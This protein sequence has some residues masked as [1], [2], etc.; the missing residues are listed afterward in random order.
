MP[1][2]PAVFDTVICPPDMMVRMPLLSRPRSVV[3]G[4]EFEVVIC[5]P[6]L[7][8]M[9]P[10]L[11]RPLPPAGLVIDSVVPFGITSSSVAFIEWPIVLIVHVL[12]AHNPPYEGHE[13]AFSVVVACASWAAKVDNVKI[14]IAKI[15]R[16]NKIFN[17][18]YYE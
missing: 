5:P 1:I 15:E 12:P 8:V 17:S 3:K 11:V 13:L 4:P 10:L 7:M 9:M 14:N 6:E 2:P 18:Y 16:W